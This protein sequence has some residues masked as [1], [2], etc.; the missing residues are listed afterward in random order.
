MVLHVKIDLLP[1]SVTKCE[2]VSSLPWPSPPVPST[3][4]LI[5]SFSEISINL[6]FLGSLFVATKV[7]RTD[8]N[9]A[10]L[11]ADLRFGFPRLS[12]IKKL[13]LTRS[14]QTTESWEIAQVNTMT[15]CK[16]YDL[17]L[18]MD[19]LEAVFNVRLVVSIWE[20]AWNL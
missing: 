10:A 4:P 15:D 16:F 19:D 5:C 6:F 2:I 18:K 9:I 7:Q 11:F 17:I 8:K 14:D 13:V 12:T 1:W 20:K 3:C